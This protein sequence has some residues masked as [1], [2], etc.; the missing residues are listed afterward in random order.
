VP[1]CL[2]DAV[3]HVRRVEK[4]DT[5]PE[6]KAGMAEAMS[7]MEFPRFEVPTLPRTFR[8]HS[9]R[10]VERLTNGSPRKPGSTTVE[11]RTSHR[12]AHERHFEGASAG[13]IELVNRSAALGP[14]SG[15]HP[16]APLRIANKGRSRCWIFPI[17]LAAV[18][19]HTRYN[20]RHGGRALTAPNA[21]GSKHS[22]ALHEIV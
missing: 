3:A 8:A 12:S 22:S 7:S 4:N 17:S 14:R 15:S 11:I 13:P 21:V 6:P 5:T 20:D 16:F 2:A 19:V 1:A 18:A 9:V 10:F